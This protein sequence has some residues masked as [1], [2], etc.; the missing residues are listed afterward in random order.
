MIEYRIALSIL[1]ACF[2]GIQCAG[3]GARRCDVCAD[4]FLGTGGLTEKDINQFT[5]AAN[6][7]VGYPEVFSELG[8]PNTSIGFDDPYP[9]RYGSS[10]YPIDRIVKY[11]HADFVTERTT[12]YTSTWARRSLGAIYIFYRGQLKFFF[13]MEVLRP[14]EGPWEF[15]PNTSK[16][17]LNQ[18]GV[19]TQKGEIFPGATCATEYYLQ[20][21]A[22][23]EDKV[24]TSCYWAVDGF[25]A[26]LRKDSE[27][28]KRRVN[29]YSQVTIE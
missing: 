25:E 14:E 15:G 6:D 3:N 26:T 21:Q 16:G 28:R 29:G 17:L 27:Y 10:F 11:V 1:T 18:I 24:S 4:D 8:K 7:S 12:R 22:K 2:L 19:T 13:L 9:Y 5:S 23:I 20:Q